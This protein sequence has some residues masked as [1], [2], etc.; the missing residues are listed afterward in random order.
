[1]QSTTKF[2]KVCYDAGKEQAAYSNHYVR[3]RIGGN[4]VC[5][6]ILSQN[7][8]YCKEVG[9]TPSHCPVLQKKQQGMAKQTKQPAT[10]QQTKQ[11]APLKVAEKQPRK[12][13][14]YTALECDDE[15]E[16][17]ALKCN[18]LKCNALKCNTLEPKCIV[19]IINP[20][21]WASVVSRPQIQPKV[22]VQAPATQAPAT[23]APAT[24]APA[25]QP[26]P[27]APATQ[28]QTQAPATQQMISW[29]DIE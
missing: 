25:T 8:K 3:D 19:P 24:Q 20:N 22:Q 28:A 11:P 10:Q 21:S 15:M 4:V 14:Y 7:C 13:N 5:P 29:A 6:L 12:Q 1:M 9:H 27:Q 26:Q 2:C 18:A 16:R 23:Q 17:N